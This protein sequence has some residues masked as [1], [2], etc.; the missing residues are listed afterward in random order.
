MADK[1]AC[2]RISFLNV[3]LDILPEE[4][5]E[6]RI[7]SMVHDNQQHQIIFLRLSDLLKA[8]KNG[9]YRTAVQKSSIVI[10]ISKSILRGAKFL[11][12]SIPT[13]YMPFEFIIKVLGILE[14]N[15]KSVY[16]FGSKPH[17]IQQVTR[18]ITDS[19]PGLNI[20]GRCSG[21]FKKEES[22]NINLAIKKASPSLLLAG[23]GLPGKDLWY[24]QNK[25][26]VNPGIYVWNKDFFDI[27]LGRRRKVSKKTW[28]AGME[29]ASESFKYPWRLFKG[30]L[31]P[32]Y[33]LI[34]LFYKIRKL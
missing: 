14:K 17:Q 2:K 8:R 6:E 19:F 20:V 5:L 10:P 3:P 11:N 26:T 22:K 13:R 7:M 23:K 25:K 30:F 32:W 33:G 9:K 1:V 34:L 24:S 21:F 16:L 18:N 15:R 12:K 4:Q 28:E 31:Y 29:A 27:T